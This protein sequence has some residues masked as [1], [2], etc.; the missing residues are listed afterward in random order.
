MSSQSRADSWMKEDL[1]AEGFLEQGKH[2]FYDV[3]LNNYTL[4]ENNDY[5]LGTSEFKSPI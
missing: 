4:K 2:K 3:L 5:A 1:R